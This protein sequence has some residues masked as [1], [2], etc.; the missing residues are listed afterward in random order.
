VVSWLS[1]LH[2]PGQG[3]LLIPLP[4]A[5]PEIGGERLKQPYSFLGG[6]VRPEKEIL[7]GC[8]FELSGSS[9]W[10]AHEYALVEP[11]ENLCSRIMGH[12]ILD[13]SLSCGFLWGT[14]VDCRQ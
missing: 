5:Y 9:L 8:L 12:C 11:I 2:P 1:G 10:V 7:P 14:E 6:K 3:Y 4:I 13:R